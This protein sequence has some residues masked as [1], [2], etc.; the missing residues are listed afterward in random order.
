MS[1]L[2]GGLSDQWARLWFGWGRSLSI[3]SKLCHSAERNSWRIQ[4]GWGVLK[5]SGRGTLQ[6]E[7]GNGRAW[8]FWLLHLCEIKSPCPLQSHSSSPQLSEALSVWHGQAVIINHCPISRDVTTRSFH[9]LTKWK[10]S[11]LDLR[12]IF[13]HTRKRNRRGSELHECGASVDRLLAHIGVSLLFCNNF[14]AKTIN[15][16]LQS[17]NAKSSISTRTNISTRRECLLNWRLSYNK[18][19]HTGMAYIVQHHFQKRCLRKQKI[20][21]CHRT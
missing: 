5:D 7:Q 4:V 16:H 2:P 11:K 15:L 12:K 3:L 13:H 17:A 20:K 6:L 10:S 19:L 1:Y 9:S 21:F 18:L 8:Q 14:R